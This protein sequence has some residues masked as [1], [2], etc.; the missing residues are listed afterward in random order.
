MTAFSNQSETH[1]VPGYW[2]PV[3]LTVELG[4]VGQQAHEEQGFSTSRLLA[5]S[6]VPSR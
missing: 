2:A 4:L 5:V 3:H 1:R 6:P